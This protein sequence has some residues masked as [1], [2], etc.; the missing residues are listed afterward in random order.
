MKKA[1]ARRRAAVKTYPATIDG[2]RVRVTIPEDPKPEEVL[3]D[4]LRENL[5]PQAVA[6]IAGYLQPAYT[7]DES[8]NRQLAW[9]QDFL[10]EVLGGDEALNR[11]ADELGL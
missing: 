3:R 11:I 6:A 9:F 8:V 2:R 10:V 5:S 4:A 7:R 1:K